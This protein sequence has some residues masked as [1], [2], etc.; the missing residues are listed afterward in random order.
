MVVKK[1]EQVKTEQKQ[2]VEEKNLIKTLKS[3]FST[4][5]KENHKMT[6]G[7]LLGWAF[8]MAL[9]V[10]VVLIGVQYALAYLISAMHLQVSEIVLQT[11]F[12]ALVYVVSLLIIILVPWKLLNMKTTREEL[13]LREL[14]TWTDILLAPIAFIVFLFLLI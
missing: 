4:K 9:W 11:I 8:L 10:G 1:K 2:S 13:G 14:P 5:A 3:R 12:S 6:I 7:A